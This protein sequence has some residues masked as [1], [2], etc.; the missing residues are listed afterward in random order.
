VDRQN[1]VHHSQYAIYFELGRTELLR[2]NGC[3]YKYLEDNG[4]KLV[5]ARME[6]RYRYPASYDE[7]LILTTILGKTDRA[8][9]EHL[10]E[11]RRPADNKLIAEGSTI[12]V[13]VD[14]EGTLQP[15]PTFFTPE[16]EA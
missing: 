16:K 9:L 12:L 10:Y 1:A 2:Q 14:E 8:R 5:I 6:I 13:H 11:L 15:M 7:E 4:I 3:A